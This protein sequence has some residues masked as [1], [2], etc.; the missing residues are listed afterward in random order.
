HAAH[1]HRAAP[2][3]RR[4][5]GTRRHRDL[6]AAVAASATA[7]GFERRASAGRREADAAALGAGADA[8]LVPLT[9]HDHHGAAGAVH[10]ERAARIEGDD[11]I[12]RAGLL[13]LLTIAIA[14]AIPLG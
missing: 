6:E 5:S 10:G 3:G 8:D 11:G 12:E 9:A 14:L 13:A 2:R 7:R 4:H 1:R